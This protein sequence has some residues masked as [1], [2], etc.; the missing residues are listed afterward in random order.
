ML[1]KSS[2]R[3]LLAGCMFAAL[4]AFTTPVLAGEAVSNPVV[5][6]VDVESVMQESSA[7][8]GVI[9]QRDKYQEQFQGEISR[10]EQSLRSTKQEL[11]QQRQKMS[12]E[13]FAEKARAF[14]QKV[15][16]FE[17]KV[18]L[19][20]RALDRSYVTAMG[21]VQE[22]MLA[23]A[24]ELAQAKGAN[25]VLPRSTVLFFDE[26]MNIS[27]EILDALNKR[28]PSVEFPTPKLEEAAQGNGAPAAASKKKSE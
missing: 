1:I 7:A 26:K 25:L 6:V 21:Q 14:D 9:A 5:V 12:P 15:A 10:E 18:V 19:R 27:K 20:R 23:A 13:A 4:A 28:L 17:R 22:N 16:E 8:K 2:K 24:N 11:D 3:S